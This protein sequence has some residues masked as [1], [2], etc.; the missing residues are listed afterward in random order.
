MFWVFAIAA[1]VLVFAIA[2]AAVGRTVA[3]LADEPT[4][5]VFQVHDAVS[6]IAS[7]LPFEAAAQLSERDVD[8]IVRWHL[9]YFA[10]VGLAGEHGQEL[11]GAAVPVGQAAVASSDES[12]DYVVERAL[13]DGT[14]IEPLHAVVVIDLLWQYWREIGAIGPEAD[15]IAEPGALESNHQ[16]K[17]GGPHQQ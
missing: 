12:V 10:Q 15:A 5:T 14:E 13:D 1:A 11:G 16:E 2:A 7:R 9:D 6:Y 4:P 3:R 17:G 8:R